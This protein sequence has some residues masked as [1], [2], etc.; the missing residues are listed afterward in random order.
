M[1]DIAEHY[2]SSGF[3]TWYV[4]LEKDGENLRCYEYK[5]RIWPDPL[6][7][8]LALSARTQKGAVTARGELLGDGLELNRLQYNGYDVDTNSDLYKYRYVPL[9]RYW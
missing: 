3:W 8:D 1:K 4:L 2:G 5:Y 9:G 7:V 6:A